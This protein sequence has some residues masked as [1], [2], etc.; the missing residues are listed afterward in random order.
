MSGEKS[1]HVSEAKKKIV[2][3]LTELAKNKK[4]IL[5]ASIKNIPSS[6]Y[7]E[8]V[9]KMRGKAIIKV[10][11]KN[12]IFKALDESGNEAVKKLKEQ[13]KENVAI[14]FSDIDS[15]ELSAELLSKTSSA[16]AKIGQEAPEDIEVQAGPTDLIPG[17]AISELGAVGI[18]IQ[19]EKGKIY[20]KESKVIVK[21]GE[22]ISSAQ[23]DV[24]SKL[25][26]KPFLVGFIPLA[27]FDTK[28]NKL[29]LD[30]KINKEETLADLKTEFG[31][32]L[33]FAVEI[34]Y[35]SGD[36]IKFMISKAGAEG[37]VLENLAPKEEVKE[38]KPSEEVIPEQ[39]TEKTVND[40]P[41]EPESQ[42]QKTQTQGENPEE[43]K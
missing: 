10:P 1:T 34:G 36:T 29:Y 25:D 30:I 28:E 12:L 2:S 42:S 40:K 23:A 21:K 3:E 31:K 6:H 26:I 22:I 32:A 9:K 24:M 41:Q 14:L 17:P 5:I 27:S 15:F 4:T 38:E 19:I 7:Q 20:I 13:I 8:I 35:I 18:P 33:G 37:K 39:P 11:K 43:N 16:K